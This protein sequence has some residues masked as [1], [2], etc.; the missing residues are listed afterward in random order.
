MSGLKFE[1]QI[2]Q[3]NQEKPT[4]LVQDNSLLIKTTPKFVDKNQEYTIPIE[5]GI[6]YEYFQL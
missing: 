2:Y 3:S 4:K 1:N 6:Y 5:K